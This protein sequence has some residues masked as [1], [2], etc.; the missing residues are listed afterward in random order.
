MAASTVRRSAR[1]PARCPSA[2]GRPRASA[3]RPLP[4]MMIATLPA[5]P[6][7]LSCPVSTSERFDAAGASNFHDFGFFV[8]HQLVDRLRVLVGQLLHLGLPAP[9]LVV[10]DLAVLD[11]LLE[12]LHHVPAD[13]PDRDLAV[14]TRLADELDELLA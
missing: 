2:T 14:L 1:V 7:A 13:V 10:A 4:S 12:M 6:G 5:S 9:L 8:L 3:Q 11:Q